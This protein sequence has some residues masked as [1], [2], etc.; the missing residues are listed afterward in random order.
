MKHTWYIK[1]SPGL[2][3]FIFSYVMRDVKKIMAM[4]FV[5]KFQLVNYF[6][7]ICL[8][9]HGYALQTNANK[10]GTFALINPNLLDASSLICR[11]DYCRGIVHLAMVC[12]GDA[13]CLAMYHNNT[14]MSCLVCT[15][16]ADP[17]R[18]NRYNGTVEG[19]LIVLQQP[20]FKKGL[21]YLMREI[22]LHIDAGNKPT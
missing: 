1:H 5:L 17:Y 16:P 8:L 13:N 3:P 22:N 14:S 19:A 15:C 6:L 11:E 18:F 21:W 9:N 2:P 7:V 12:H 10:S 20:C 4:K